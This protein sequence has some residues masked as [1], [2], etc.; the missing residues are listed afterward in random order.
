MQGA[1]DQS[2]VGELRYHMLRGAAQEKKKQKEA[3]TWLE[4]EESGSPRIQHLIQLLK[5]D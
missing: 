1:Q 5:N 4:E 3:S 2:L